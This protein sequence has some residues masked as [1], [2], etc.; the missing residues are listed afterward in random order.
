VNV[1]NIYIDALCFQYRAGA[2]SLRFGIAFVEFVICCVHGLFLSRVADALP[3]LPPPWTIDDNG[4]LHCEGRRP[5]G[6]GNAAA[7]IVSVFFQ[8]KSALE[9]R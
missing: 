9:V 6:P 2:P 7:L 4:V 3:P 8:S 5:Y 1:N